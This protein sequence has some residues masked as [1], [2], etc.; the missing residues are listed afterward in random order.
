MVVI[1]A[2]SSVPGSAI[3]G[4]VSV[5]SPLAHLIE[6]AVLAAFLVFA[7]G[8]RRLTVAVALA[9]LLAC[10]IYGASDEFHQR[11]TPG[12]TPDPVDWATDTVGAGLA[13]GAIAIVRRRR[14]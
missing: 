5:Y 11:F 4:A 2:A 13:L 3:P 8:G 10:S 1:F 7:L 12:R 6:Y 9:L 14:A